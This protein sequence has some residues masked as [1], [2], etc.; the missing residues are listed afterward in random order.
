[1]PKSD[2]EGLQRAGVAAR[3][4]GLGY[5]DNPGFFAT[6]PTDTT[7]QLLAWHDLCCA[8]AAGWKREDAGRDEALQRVLRMRLL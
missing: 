5:H 4:A 3:I 7:E 2:L 8:W 6:V 1:M